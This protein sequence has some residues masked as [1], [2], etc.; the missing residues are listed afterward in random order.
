MKST[1]CLNKAVPKKK[2]ARRSSNDSDDLH[3]AANNRDDVPMLENARMGREELPVTGH[4]IDEQF[5]LTESVVR[6]M[7]KQMSCALP[8]ATTDISKGNK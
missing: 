6:P 7:Q 4:S 5:D 3:S 8:T 1:K 2:V